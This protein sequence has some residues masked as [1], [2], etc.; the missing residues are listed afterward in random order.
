LADIAI[1]SF[2]REPCLMQNT[3]RHFL[4]VF[5]VIEKLAHWALLG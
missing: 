1:L 4:E 2:F 5:D 3:A